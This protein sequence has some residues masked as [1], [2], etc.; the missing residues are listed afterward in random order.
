M[1]TVKDVFT[2]FRQQL[3]PLYDEQELE[4]VTLLVLNEIT[5]K[6]KAQL[7]AFPETALTTSQSEQIQHILEQ[8][9]SGSPVQY[10][11]GSTEFYGLTFKVTPAVLI[12]RVETEELVDWILQEL[13]EWQSPS[14]LRILD[15]GTGSGCIAISLKLNYINN[16][17][18][19]I[20]ISPS[21]LQVAKHNAAINKAAVNFIEADILNAEINGQ[22]AQTTYSVIVSNPPYV[23]ETDKR[24][25]HNR[26]TGFEPHSALFV[27]EED[28]L[29]FYKA[30]ADF[31]LKH[32]LSGGM[33]FFEINENF[34]KETVEM[35]ESK[36][37][38]NT[39]L[40]KDMYGKDRMI[41][42]TR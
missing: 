3:Q 38:K 33:L 39:Q 2:T 16:E 41:K 10:A 30:I 37:F 11:I 27:P 1:E 21:A 9:L 35:L 42:A 32:L 22:L 15:I 23:T 13:K 26:V 34:G 40:R 19:A 36:G 6:S 8:L 14:L 12:P 18:F 25:M 5:G 20:D 29:L 31:A 4:A 24:Q 28:P 17:S 7:K